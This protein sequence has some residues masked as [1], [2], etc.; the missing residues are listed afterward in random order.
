MAHVDAPEE[1][2]EEGGSVGQ[3]PARSSEL[4]KPK[5]SQIPA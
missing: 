5:V 2:P 1:E 3:R 4:L